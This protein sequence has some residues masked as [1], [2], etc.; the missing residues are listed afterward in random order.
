MT[1]ICHLTTNF[2]IN[3]DAYD[4]KCACPVV[5]NICMESKN[6]WNILESGKYSNNS[7]VT[8]VIQLKARIKRI[9]IKNGQNSKILI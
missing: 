3:V 4:K 6:K 2:Y 9:I 8:E 7:E 1:T 5:G